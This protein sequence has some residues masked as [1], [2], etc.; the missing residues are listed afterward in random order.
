MPARYAIYYTP[1]PDSLLERRVSRLFGR[2]L[3]STETFP[4][5]PPAGFAP[6]EWAGIVQEPAHYGLHATLKAPFTLREGADEAALR[7]ACHKLALRHTPFATLPLQLEVLSSR[8]GK[9]HFLA[10]TPQSGPASEPAVQALA[11]LE[12][13]CV[14]SFESLRAP[15]TEADIAARGRL[16][17]REERYLRTFGYHLILDLFRFHITLTGC[18]AEADLA[19]A[20]EALTPVLADFLG[21]PLRLDAISLCVQADRTQPFTECAR[22]L[23]GSRPESTR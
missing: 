14:V 15:L 10:L 5:E 12:K 20:R 16:T 4:P 13:D 21:R 2:T 6:G 1:A 17:D 7:S 9:G 22:F 3:Q 8:N 18:L 11:A 19:R 23:L